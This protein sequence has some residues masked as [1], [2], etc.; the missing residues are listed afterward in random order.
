ML[1]N[2]V[3]ST[4]A[5]HADGFFNLGKHRN[6][7]GGLPHNSRVLYRRDTNQIRRSSNPPDQEKHFGVIKGWGLGFAVEPTNQCTRYSHSGENPG[8]LAFCAFSRKQKNG[9]VFFTN[10]DQGGILNMRLRIF[11]DE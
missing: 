1:Q 6:F 5:W 8:F 9:Y 2:Y 11:L 4:L 7:T 10:G 3:F